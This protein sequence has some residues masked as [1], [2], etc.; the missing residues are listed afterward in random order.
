M[1]LAE[2]LVADLR[3]AMVAGDTRRR[4]VIRFL[5]ASITNAQIEKHRELTDEEIQDV[6][7]GQVKQR[8]DA[9]D[10][11]RKGGR[12]ELVES[13]TAEIAI[14]Q[15]YLPQQLSEDEVR[16]IVQRVAEELGASG[17]R[18]M[19]RLMPELMK[20]TGGRVEGR[21][22]STLARAELDRRAA[23]N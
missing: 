1:T 11:F 15:D 17:P 12:E 23:A 19:G 6:I 22:L 3:A 5:R 13:E 7:R 21:T 16:E 20:A 4:D 14:L 8:R 18:D 9:I 10:M 2:Q